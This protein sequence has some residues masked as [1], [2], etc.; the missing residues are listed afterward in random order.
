M[1][2]NS[3][4]FDCFVYG[5]TMEEVC[6]ALVKRFN[7]E[8]EI[9]PG[10]EDSEWEL[11]LHGD[12]GN[13]MESFIT[14]GTAYG[15]RGVDVCTVFSLGDFHWWANQIFE[16]LTDALPNDVYMV[17]NS[18]DPMFLRERVNGVYS[19]EELKA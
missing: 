14:Y 6:D 13:Y 11:T 1:N 10:Y 7:A 15:E 4:S 17:Q 8:V 19:Y 12:D 2:Y 3:S 16:C 5:A 9:E 18:L